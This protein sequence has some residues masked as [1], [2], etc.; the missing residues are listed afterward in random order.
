MATRSGDLPE[1]SEDSRTTPERNSDSGGTSLLT[2]LRL[3]RLPTVFTALS[4]ILC[5]YF[6]THQVTIGQLTG[7]RD[8][9]LLLLASAGLY[10]GG[11]VLNDVCDAAI[12]GVERPERA[13]PSGRISRRAAGFLATLLMAG[14][15]S[16]AAGVGTGSLIIAGV[17]SCAVIA[18]DA[19]MKNTAAGP[20]TMASCRFLNILL[21][22]SA[23]AEPGQILSL[24]QT[25]V[26]AGLFVY[27]IGVT[28][29]ARNEAG[30]SDRRSLSIAVATVLA[31]IA[32]DAA[33]ICLS[34]FPQRSQL[35]GCL[36]LGL[37]A[38]NLTLRCCSAA[39]NPQPRII[40]RTVGFLLLSIIFLDAAVVFAKTGNASIAAVVVILV[41]PATL[42]KRVI[43]LS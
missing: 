3:M 33:V 10:L 25:G 15:I 39:R 34:D 6:L 5:G 11:M 14:G 35:G 23:V 27:I 18:Y 13:I 21:G 24:P 36:A 1:I 32:I 8:L 38:V 22:A 40:Q 2:W 30:M 31:G 42:L 19:F 37:V 43:P 4:N 29:F 26:G 41:I 20:A 7:E 16:A 9:L 17:L 12:D 28:L